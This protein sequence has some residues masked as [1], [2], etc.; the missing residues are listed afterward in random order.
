[1]DQSIHDIFYL[2]SRKDALLLYRPNGSAVRHSNRGHWLLQGRSSW[3]RHLPSGQD[4]RW[5]VRRYLPEGAKLWLCDVRQRLSL[6]RLIP[7]EEKRFQ[8]YSVYIYVWAHIIDY[9]IDFCNLLYTNKQHAYL[10]TCESTNKLSISTW[11]ATILYFLCTLPSSKFPGDP[12]TNQPKQYRCLHQWC[13][14]VR[15]VAKSPRILFD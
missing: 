12:I 5:P 15:Y 4:Q 2:I 7:S 10:Y 13:L 1:M 3:D 9:F 14:L 8:K 11:G 6:V